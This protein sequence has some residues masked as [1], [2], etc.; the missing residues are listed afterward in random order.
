MIHVSI[1][2]Q[3]QLRSERGELLSPK[4]L[5]LLVAID[6]LGSLA[7]ACQQ[8]G[9]S[10]RHAWELLRTAEQF[11]GEP[12]VVKSRGRGTALTPLGQQLV[13]AQ[14]ELDARLGPTLET[15]TAE[16]SAGIDALNG[17]GRPR[18]RL[19]ACHGQAV[20]ALASAL[21]TQ[22]IAHTLR[23]GSSAEVIDAL[24]QGQCD[25][26]GVHVPLG[27]VAH[28]YALAL[29]QGLNTD[30][31]HVIHL[32]VRRQ[33]LLTAAG[34]P[35]RIQQLR[36]LLRPGIRFLNRPPGS[37][38]RRL[39]DALLKDAQIRPSGI[40]GYERNGTTHTALTAA[41]ASRQVD[42]AFGPEPAERTLP[43]EFLP[44]QL[45]RYVLLCRNDVSHS[46]AQAARAVLVS[47]A[48]QRSL[49]TLSGETADDVGRVQGL[50]L[51]LESL[52]R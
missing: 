21:S 12:V 15:M 4:A 8:T 42:A 20:Q 26:A 25:W 39:L 5:E 36:D 33:G 37:G 49:Q 46:A 19:H 13:W 47:P 18:L 10:Y 11:F 40:M 31:F 27:P 43:V 16:L 7:A 24:H 30:T 9:N 6:E 3:L 51:F 23:F 28:R 14:H 41:V 52:A 44:L 32:A 38:T 29:L 35:H 17:H 48:L 34:N 45:E 50:R 1:R 2:P 22:G